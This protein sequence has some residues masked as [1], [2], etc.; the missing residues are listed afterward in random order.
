MDPRGGMNMNGQATA[1]REMR[2]PSGVDDILRTLNTEGN[3]NS[4]SMP[5]P[6]GIDAEEVASIGSGMTTETMRRRGVSRRRATTT[7]PTGATLTLN[8]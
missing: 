1:R 7:Q 5:T 6:A 2:G 3:A 8:V 4:R